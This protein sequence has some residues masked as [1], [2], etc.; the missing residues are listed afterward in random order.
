M[1]TKRKAA[2]A[3]RMPA[4]AHVEKRNLNFCTSRQFLKALVVKAAVLGFMPYSIADFLVQR[5]GLRDA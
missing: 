1:T 5:G 3:L 4:A 2:G